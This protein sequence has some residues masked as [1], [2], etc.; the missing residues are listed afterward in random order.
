MGLG[1]ISTK[2]L[3]EYKADISDLKAKVKE[4]GGHEKALGEARLK[5]AEAA[6]K[7]IENQIKTIG[8]ISTGLQFANAAGIDLG[9]TIQKMTGIPI[10]G[11]GTAI[12]FMLGGPAGAA[13]GTLVEAMN[14]GFD[15]LV[16]MAK[17]ADRAAN[18]T[19]T[20]ADAIARFQDNASVAWGVL[21]EVR[22]G[23]AATAAAASTARSQIGDFNL[24]LELSGAT[25]SKKYHD[26]IEALNRVLKEHPDQ[27]DLVGRAIDNLNGKHD[28][29][30]KSV[31][32]H[33]S[34]LAE[35]A[36]ELRRIS[37]AY[38]TK[39]TDELLEREIAPSGV[40]LID[41]G[42]QSRAYEPDQNLEIR[43]TTAQSGGMED[44]LAKTRTEQEAKTAAL[45][46]VAEATRR[47]SAENQ[48]FGASFASLGAVAGDVYGALID[49]TDD[50]GATVKR[51]SANAIKALGTEFLVKGV[52]QIAE[53]VAATA[54]VWG[55][56]KAPGHY[57]A[58]AKFLAAAGIAGIAAAALGGGGGG[59]G[60]G[61]RP[62]APS[63][64]GPS[65]GGSSE[66]SA[67]VIV[68]GSPFAYDSP[69]NQQKNAKRLTGLA[70]GTNSVVYG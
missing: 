5:A 24:M 12:G 53:G 8:R 36:K 19:F 27:A 54:S 47:A 37:D 49:G 42:Q 60:A 50:L 55:A 1:E 35:H 66:R 57:A 11:Q 68:V 62:S 26:Q 48:I 28:A 10:G 41:G 38:A 61:A 70:L 25:A 64:N 51:A 33:T 29:G 44:W 17:E 58:G 56:W 45:D 13:V 30:A 4:L 39:V 9:G 59:G 7:G 16:R 63:Y 20:L 40:S 34:A 46:A 2:V 23:F 69:R 43:G 18:A 6:N 22:A 3:V 67:P 21:G 15:G 32:S 65:N 31:R 52:G 14:D